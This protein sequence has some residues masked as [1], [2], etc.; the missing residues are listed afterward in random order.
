MRICHVQVILKW[1]GKSLALTQRA[2]I[3]TECYSRKSRLILATDP[4]LP[5][6]SNFGCWLRIPFCYVICKIQRLMGWNSVSL[7]PTKT[8]VRLESTDELEKETSRTFLCWEILVITQSRKWNNFILRKLFLFWAQQNSTIIHSF[9]S[10]TPLWGKESIWK[11]GFF[12]CNSK[13][14]WISLENVEALLK[15]IVF[16]YHLALNFFFYYWL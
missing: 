4:K 1:C 10:F 16:K 9:L 2:A 13:N 3:G 6:F 14:T 8:S 15:Q 7:M 12:F 5:K 11:F